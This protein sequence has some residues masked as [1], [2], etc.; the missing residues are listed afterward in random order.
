MVE[1]YEETFEWRESYPWWKVIDYQ[2]CQLTTIIDIIT[3]LAL[4][5]TINMFKNKD[6]LNMFKNI[7]DTSERFP[8]HW[9]SY[10]SSIKIKWH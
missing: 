10:K 4:P 2:T 3:F 7:V 6:C 5:Y 8:K 1:Y 9:S